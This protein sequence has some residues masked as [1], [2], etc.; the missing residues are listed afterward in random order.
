MRAGRGFENPY[1][2]SYDDLWEDLMDEYMLPR[3]A[4]RNPAPPYT[5]GLGGDFGEDPHDGSYDDLWNELMD[6]YPHLRDASP[7]AEGAIHSPIVR[8]RSPYEY[9]SNASDTDFEDDNRGSYADYPTPYEFYT[10]SSSRECAFGMPGRVCATHCPTPFNEMPHGFPPDSRDF[11][12]APYDEPFRSHGALLDNFHSPR[13]YHQAYSINDGYGGFAPRNEYS[14]LAPYSYG[15]E[16]GGLPDEYP[17]F[18]PRG[19]EYRHHP[20][21]HPIFESYDYEYPTIGA[22]GHHLGYYPPDG[23]LP[24]YY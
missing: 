3:D 18:G 21:Q 17:V 19:G 7:R 15:R 8:N 16:F 2:G 4:Y 5:S 11:Y 24:R 23:Y 13:P 1:D 12:S 14:H 9:H 6:D 22:H 20:D 10:R